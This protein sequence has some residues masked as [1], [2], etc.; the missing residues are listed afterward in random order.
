MNILNVRYGHALEILL[1]TV[2]LLL[3]LHFSGSSDHSRLCHGPQRTAHPSSWWPVWSWIRSHHKLRCQHGSSG[4][5]AEERSGGSSIWRI[6]R[7]RCATGLPCNGLPA[8]HPWR[9]PDILIL[10]MRPRETTKSV[11]LPVTEWPLTRHISTACIIWK[12]LSKRN[13]VWN[14]CSEHRQWNNDNPTSHIC[15][16]YWPQYILDQRQPYDR[17][18]YA[19]LQQT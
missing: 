6:H 18:N 10:R 9:V 11:I 1:L 7:L 17:L 14:K 15:P 16:T 13:D 5:S 12:C 8:A 3:L 19:I 4:C 2:C